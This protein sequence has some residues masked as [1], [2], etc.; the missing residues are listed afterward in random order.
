MRAEAQDVAEPDS[1]RISLYVDGLPEV[2]EAP[3]DSLRARAEA[4]VDSLRTQGRYF[5]SIDSLF[6]TRAFVS[7]GPLVRVDRVI[8]EGV[9]DTETEVIRLAMNTREGRVLDQEVL[10]TDFRAILTRY[11]SSGYALA[12]V[13]V[14]EID[15][16]PAGGLSITINVSKGPRLRLERIELPGADRTSTSFVTRLVGHQ[17]GAFL[18]GYNPELIRR[19]L[20]GTG[21][22]ANVGAPELVIEPDTAAVLVI[23]LEEADPGSFDLVLGYLPPEGPGDN[24]I[25]VGNGSLELRNLVGGGR[26]ISIQLNRMPGSASSVDLRAA[27]PFL[28]GL[29][30]GLE[31]GFQGLEQDSTYGKQAY[32]GEVAYR[33]EK[34]LSASAGFSREVTRPGQAGLQLSSSGRQVIPRSD[35]W[36][37]GLGMH[38]ESLDRRVNPTKG[39]LIE[40]YLE[41]GS[42][43]FTDR[44]IVGTDTTSIIRQ[45]DQRRLQGSARLYLPVFH[46]QVVVL[47]GEGGVLLSD[48]Y[49]RSDLFRFGGATSLRGYDEE[50]FLGRIVT[51]ALAEY[52]FLIDR[53]SF[54]YCFIDVGYV[55]RPETPDL[56]RTHDIHPGYGIGIQFRT[57]IGLVNVSAALNPDSG[58]T[59]ARIHA[60]LSFGL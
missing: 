24:G 41:T 7:R 8:V 53:T 15:L 18:D 2:R 26:R 19:R 29:P 6:D 47:G 46:R 60:G 32:S 17:P 23:P 38:Y 9:D 59:D 37:V 27:D 4:L 12:S 10:E 5:A 48:S 40:T 45:A 50:R 52:R 3:A 22:F 28:L 13:S 21:L 42:K 11:Q 43:E 31:G 51:R 56:A 30:L 1:V 58:P 14:E 25:L 39:L 33:F 35:G 36:F 16:S 44:R 49:D 20:E 54:A 57:A 34:G 55:D